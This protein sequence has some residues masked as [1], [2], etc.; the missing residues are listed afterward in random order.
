MLGLVCG[1]V[2]WAGACSW[3]VGTLRAFSGLPL[4]V[5]AAIALLFW[6]FHGG[7]FALFAWLWWRAR[8]RGASAALA[9]AAAFASSELVYPQLF[10][11]RYAAS[12]HGLPPAL[13]I[14]ELG[15]ALLL[16]ALVMAVSGAVYELAARPRC[17][18]A[19]RAA[20][21]LT[22]CI[23]ASLVYGGVRIRQIDASL[24]R[25]P[26]IRVGIVQPNMEAF[27]KWT[28]RREGQRRLIEA[29]R[30][31][32]ASVKPDL[33]LWPENA[34]VAALP[35]RLER[36]P[37]SLTAGARTPLLLGIA[38][39]TRVGDGWRPLNRVALADEQGA[40]RG[41]YDKVSLLA[42]GEYLPFEE[43][44]PWLR[45]LS[46]QSGRVQAGSRVD[47]LPYR[48]W[49]ISALVCIEDILPGFVRRVMREAAPH[50][51]VNLTNDAW[52]GDTDAPWLHLRL[53]QLRAV[54]QRRYLVRATNT[55]VSAVIDPLGRVVA[56]SGSFTRETLHA[57]VAMLE[58][59]TLYQRLG[60]WPGWVSVAASLWLGF[61]RPARAQRQPRDEDA[62]S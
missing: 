3:V 5:C 25:A 24:A 21:A 35:V 12:L 48:E 15:G 45:A 43:R 17:R 34:W 57:Q 41:T 49:R 32:E 44:L 37:E 46:P 16:G 62:S 40:V 47:P 33:I 53:A 6:I 10:P 4:V 9:G 29:T 55:G 38:T 50:L 54:E 13:Q 1:T 22:A 18:G 8:R 27:A 23:I 2:A 30:E 51:L 60:D 14:A 42:F 20:A 26:H 59:Q 39:R 52:F 58:G 31:L 56:R 11:G 19:R 7:L 28:H 61:A 36:L